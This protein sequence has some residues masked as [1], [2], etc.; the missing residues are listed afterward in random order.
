MNAIE[1]GLYTKLTS[2]TALIAELGATAIYNR[3]APQGTSMPLVI[4]NHAGGGYENVNPSSLQNHV[5]LVKAVATGS[6]AAGTLDG[7]ILSALHG[8][9]LTVS[10]YTNFY[11]AAEQEVQL[12]ETARDGTFI[13]HTGHYYRIRIDD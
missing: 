5:Y 1:A 6:K 7:L 9:A 3:H 12:T 8:Q 2:D 10:G 4:F 11:M 13:Y